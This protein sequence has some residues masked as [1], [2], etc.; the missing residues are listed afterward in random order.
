MNS[1]R[2]RKL[3]SD[4]RS[5][6]AL[7]AALAL[8]TAVG[9]PADVESA[10]SPMRPVVRAKGYLTEDE[11]PDSSALLP[12]PPASGSAALAL[13][14]ALN[15]EVL[16]LR[17]TARWDLAARDAIPNPAGVFSC[18]L[19]MPITEEDTPSLYRLLNRSV[20][21]VGPVVTRTKRLYQRKRPFLINEEPTCVPRAEGSTARDGSYPSGH[22]AAGW[23]WALILAEIAPDKIDALLS[24]GWEFGQSRAVCNV[25]Y[26]SDVTAGRTVGAALVARLHAKEEFRADLDSA[27]EEY[28]AVREKGLSPTRDCKAEAAALAVDAD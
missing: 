1:N 20:A 10:A 8:Q 16:A 14:E 13:D 19:D 2:I 25:H 6:F 22:T 18:A 23:L 28:A 21:D 9:Q 27:R 7:V 11:Y 12:A 4:S 26:Q 17:G 24:R 15:R 5:L 3:T